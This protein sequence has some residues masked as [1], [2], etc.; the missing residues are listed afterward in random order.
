[1]SL[2][3]NVQPKA[4][5]RFLAFLRRYRIALAALLFVVI[6]GAWYVEASCAPDP[7]CLKNHRY[8]PTI[9]RCVRC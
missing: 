6:G 2:Q 8:N 3:E 4:E 5:N 7:L 1:M 9:R